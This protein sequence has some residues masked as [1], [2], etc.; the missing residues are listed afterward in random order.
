MHRDTSLRRASR[1]LFSH[2]QANEPVPFLIQPPLASKGG[3]F[4]RGAKWSLVNF[5]AAENL[6]PSPPLSTSWPGARDLEIESAYRLGRLRYLCPTEIAKS[7]GSTLSCATMDRVRRNHH[8]CSPTGAN[9]GP[10]NNYFLSQS[11]AVRLP[12]STLKGCRRTRTPTAHSSPESLHSKGAL[13]ATPVFP[14][15]HTALPRGP[16]SYLDLFSSNPPSAP[17]QHVQFS[18]L[19][20]YTA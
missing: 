15:L 20:R 17:S 13:S 16:S 9:P 6:T 1:P 14:C 19:T 18:E 11:R 12:A 4:T 7:H 3:R 2:R 10:H 8:C 5:T